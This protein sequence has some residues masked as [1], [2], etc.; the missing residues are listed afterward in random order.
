MKRFLWLALTA[1]LFPIVASAEDVLSDEEGEKLIL[2]QQQ[3][4]RRIQ[5]TA[6]N[7]LGTKSDVFS[8]HKLNYAV[9]GSDDLML[10]YGFKY[11][12]ID[13]KQLYVAFTN[14]MIWE[15]YKDSIPVYDN[16]FNP[17]LFYRFTTGSKWLPVIDAG[18]WHLSNGQAGLTGRSWDRLATRILFDHSDTKRPSLVS[19]EIFPLTLSKG[20][21][22]EDIGQYLGWWNFNAMVKNVFQHRSGQG[23]DVGFQLWSGANGVPFDKGNYKINVLYPF[24]LWPNFNP[25]LMLQYFDGYGEVIRDYNIKTEKLRFGVALYY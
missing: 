20:D 4:E 5:Q 25:T 3:A 17:E 11:R 9:V 15:V 14:Y 22:N 8:L 23:M 13:T 19:V 16:N 10:Q 18:Y 24:H 2:Q 12:A 1:F 7:T 6:E 21:H